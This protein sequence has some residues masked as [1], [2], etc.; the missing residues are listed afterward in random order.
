MAARATA[1]LAAAEE[2]L[3]AD[4]VVA[5]CVYVLESFYEVERERIAVLMRAAMRCHRSERLTAHRCSA[6]S[7]YTSLCKRS[8]GRTA[9]S[10]GA[11][12]KAPTVIP[13][14]LR[15]GLSAT[16]N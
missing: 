15:S 13:A 12:R 6:R 9:L 11:T 16:V 1:A 10:S 8:A 3:L 2:L 4:L 14:V 7:R 5:E